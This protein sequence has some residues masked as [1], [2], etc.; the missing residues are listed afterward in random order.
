MKRTLCLAALAL[1]LV[2]ITAVGC[3]SGTSDTDEQKINEHEIEIRLAPIHEA[4]VNIAESFPPQI[5]IYI[6]GGLTDSCTTFHD[7]TEERSGNTIDIEVTT[8]RPKEA[9][10]AQ[11]YGFFEQNVALGSDFT[12]GKSYTIN[13]NDK[14]TSFV[15]Q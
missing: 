10:C 3:Q 15:M 2:I 1:T 6:K 13:V 8:Q 5:F 12:S 11:V 7:L 4:Q 14:T 9:M